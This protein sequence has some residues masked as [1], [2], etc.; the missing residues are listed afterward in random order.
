M[1][2]KLPELPD[3][4]WDQI[5]PFVKEYPETLSCPPRNALRNGALIRAARVCKVSI[6][7]GD[8]SSPPG[9]RID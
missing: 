6:S 4:V 1:S 2:S 8:I 5:L 3:E 9:G 7:I